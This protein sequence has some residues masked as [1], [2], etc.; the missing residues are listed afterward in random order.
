[1]PEA[2]FYCPIPYE[3]LHVATEER[4]AAEIAAGPEGLLD[5]IFAL[6]AD[7]IAASDPDWATRVSLATLDADSFADA[8]FADRATHDPFRWAAYN[9]REVE[10]NKRDRR[11]VPWRYAILRLHEAVQ[12]VVPHLSEADRDRF[13]A[14]LSRVFVDNYAA[15]PSESIRRLLALRAAGVIGVLELGPDYDMMVEEERT[16]IECASETHP[17]DI[18]IDARGQKPLATR[19]LPF[20]K[21]RAQLLA[22]GDDIPDVSDDYTLTAPESA[23]RRIVLAALPYLMHDQPFIQGITASAEIGRAVAI[24]ATAKPASR[25]RRRLAWSAF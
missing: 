5:R 13:D 24:A 8:Y 4:I 9:L 19:D 25:L 2:D 1:M 7:E 6:V 14:G 10:R 3:P 16:T 21:L 15:V 20:P 17:F 22:T 18:S 11:T 23:K 12:E